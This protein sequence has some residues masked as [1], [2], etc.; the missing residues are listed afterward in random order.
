[1]EDREN[2]RAVKDFAKIVFIPFSISIINCYIGR[3]LG[4]RGVSNSISG[5]TPIDLVP[6]LGSEGKE[7]PLNRLF[8]A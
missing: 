7:Q 6:H 4:S 5:I 1:M 3:H 8:H 2:L